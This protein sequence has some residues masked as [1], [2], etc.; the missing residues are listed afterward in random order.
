MWFLEILLG[1]DRLFNAVAGGDSRATISGRVG[2]FSKVKNSR[3]WRNL[4]RI[5]NYSFLP[6]DGP[7]HC[8]QAMK[9]DGHYRRGNDIGMAALSI[10]VVLGCVV[11]CPIT[12][13]IARFRK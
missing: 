2:Y 7:G 13:V 9:K 11:I 3:Y 4:E 12:R 6:I 5:I 1:F 8:Q 10:F